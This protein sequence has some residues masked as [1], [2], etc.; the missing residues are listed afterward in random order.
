MLF[1][2]VFTIYY[3]PSTTSTSLIG[4]YY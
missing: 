1:L 4:A 3:S 2:S